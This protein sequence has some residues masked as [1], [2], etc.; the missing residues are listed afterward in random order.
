MFFS[1]LQRFVNKRAQEEDERFRR[2]LA[3]YDAHNARL[4]EAVIR[5]KQIAKSME[6]E[7][8]RIVNARSSGRSG[9]F[10]LDL[11]D[12]VAHGS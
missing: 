5:A 10:K 4:D 3:A 11:P 9:E 7:R 12:E 8:L 6:A 2:N 1:L